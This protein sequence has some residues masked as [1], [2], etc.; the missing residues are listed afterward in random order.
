MAREI[1][2]KIYAALGIERDGAPPIAPV[3]VVPDAEAEAAEVEQA[4][5]LPTPSRHVGRCKPSPGGV[6]ARPFA[7]SRRLRPGQ[8]R[9][10]G[11][12]VT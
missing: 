9:F 10:R 12:I 3:E 7:T 11:Q 4:I 6:L 2:D 1:E 8:A 5:A